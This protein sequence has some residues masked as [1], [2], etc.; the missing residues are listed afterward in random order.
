MILHTFIALQPHEKSNFHSGM[1]TPY[2]NATNNNIL[3][4]A[5]ILSFVVLHA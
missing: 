3:L 5:F 2:G 1:H 4:I